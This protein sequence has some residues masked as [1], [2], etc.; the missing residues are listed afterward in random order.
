MLEIYYCSSETHIYLSTRLE[1]SGGHI[2]IDQNDIVKE[3]EI[4][5][6]KIYSNKDD[7]LSEINLK[8]Y[9][10]NTNLP[11]LTDND[12][13]WLEGD[14]TMSELTKAL[15]NMKNNKNPGTDGLSSE[16]FKVFWGKQI[17]T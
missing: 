13:K 9:L 2:L 15:K 8:E 5:Y 7:P 6:K 14:I 17:T 4:F 16:Y 3:A 12:S 10:K 1:L 11:K